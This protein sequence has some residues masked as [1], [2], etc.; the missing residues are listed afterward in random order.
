MNN[1]PYADKEYYKE[2]YNGSI[3]P[4]VDINKQL[5][6]ATRHIDTLTYNRIVGRGISNLTE[7]QVDIIKE[8]CCMLAEFEYENADMINSTLQNYGINGITMSFGEGWNLKVQ[9]GIA[10][11]RDVFEQLSQTGLC[12][13]T[14]GRW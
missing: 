5:K 7:F 12:C 3:I 4:D 11:R 1:I 13:K 8:V 9:N 14:I 6:Q 10:I 2:V